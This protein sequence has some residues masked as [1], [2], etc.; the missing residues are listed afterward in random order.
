MYFA[1][2]LRFLRRK[3]ELSQTQLGDI[4]GTDYNTVSRYEQG[5]STPRLDVFTKLAALF[6]VNAEALRTTDLTA[7]V[8]SNEAPML[9]QQLPMV[10]QPVKHPVSILIEL[11]GTA[12]CLTRAIARLQALNL[13]VAETDML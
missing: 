9:S 12:R 8:P 1:K 6:K 5:K 4:L 13:T 11:D 2:N 7:A 3:A 10:T